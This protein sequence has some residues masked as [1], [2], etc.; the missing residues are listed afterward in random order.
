MLGDG[1]LDLSQLGDLGSQLAVEQLPAQSDGQLLSN[2]ASPASEFAFD[3]NNPDHSPDSPLRSPTSWHYRP[4]VSLP[5]QSNA[6]GAASNGSITNQR[7]LAVQTKV[8]YRTPSPD[9]PE[10]GAGGDLDLFSGDPNTEVKLKPVIQNCTS[11]SEIHPKS[12]QK[13]DINSGVA[14]YHTTR[15]AS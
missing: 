13:P 10:R 5:R 2:R 7:D 6:L 14:R 12:R 3:C 15:K 1:V 8:E 11:W 9:L 4:L